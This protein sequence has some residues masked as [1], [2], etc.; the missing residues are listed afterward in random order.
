MEG[1]V[2]IFVERK[3][4]YIPFQTVKVN[5]MELPEDAHKAHPCEAPAKLDRRTLLVGAGATLAGVLGLRMAGQTYFGAKPVFL[6]RGQH[7]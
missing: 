2:S 5:A 3:W 7:Y 4:G 1:T 6:A